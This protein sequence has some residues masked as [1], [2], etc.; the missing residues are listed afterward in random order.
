M[1]VCL[2]QSHAVPGPLDSSDQGF[3]ISQLWEVRAHSDTVSGQIA[4]A[5]RHVLSVTELRDLILS[6]CLSWAAAAGPGAVAFVGAGL[7]WGSHCS[8]ND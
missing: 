7:C 5:R 3:V 4:E 6:G 8:R 2:Q 1:W